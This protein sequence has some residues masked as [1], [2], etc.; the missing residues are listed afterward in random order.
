M[1]KLIIR[2]SYSF[3][4]R[5][6]HMATNISIRLQSKK[7]GKNLNIFGRVNLV[8]PQNLTIGSNVNINHDVYINAYNPIEIGND[9]TLS[10]GVKLISTGD[11]IRKFL[12]NKKGHIISSGIRIGDH[13]RIGANSIILSKANIFG[14]YVVVAAGSVLTKPITESYV[15]VGGVPAR[16]IKRLD[17]VEDGKSN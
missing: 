11:D 14:S 6:D 7:V 10:A 9:V 12:S 1:F 3:F 13:V 15:I 5:L 8:C 2:K 4:R 16:V 17:P